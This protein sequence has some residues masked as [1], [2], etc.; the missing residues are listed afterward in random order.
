[1]AV[2]A[3]IFDP[4]GSSFEGHAVVSSNQPLAVV[5]NGIIKSPGSGSATTN[6]VTQ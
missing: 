1:M 3:G 4:L 5:L 6:G 2:C